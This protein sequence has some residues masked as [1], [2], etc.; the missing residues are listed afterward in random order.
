VRVLVA[1]DDP[2]M[3]KLLG[4]LVAHWGLQA[5]YASDG[6]EALAVLTGWSP[7]DR[8]LIDWM[9]PGLPGPDVCRR[10]R[11]AGCRARLVMLTALSEP[12]R[13]VEGLEAGADDYVGKPFDAAVLRARLL[14]AGATPER[15]APEVL[16]PGVVLGRFRLESVLGEG[17]MGVV[18]K[19]THV[20]LGH[21]AAVKV[22]RGD[23]AMQ[24]RPRARFEREARAM[25]ML[26]SPNVVR[27]FDYGVSPGGL[28][29]LVM[30]YLRGRTLAQL[31]AERGP[32][33][34]EDVAQ[35]ILEIARGLSA[36]H[37]AG[38]VHRDVKPENVFLED[39]DG[40]H[41]LGRPFQAKLLDFGLAR[42]A[43]AGPSAT[44]RGC[45]V[46]TLGY[47]S[48]EQVKG[49]TV[50]PAS[51][52]W[53]LGAT[54]F[55]ALTGHDAIADGRE[56]AMMRR[57][58]AGVTVLPTALAPRLP[59]AVDAWLARACAVDPNARFPD[60]VTMAEALRRAVW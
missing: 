14:R 38:L 50:S 25:S 28:P 52:L 56:S 31:L 42:S 44:G 55:A 6:D 18:F 54:A 8:A 48:P 21:P 53:S 9:M 20:E 34:P 1:D 58:K 10:A 27:I 32:L 45:F 2:E 46:G 26:R 51:D 11:A 57:T 39:T 40:D 41:D 33:P 47:A 43:L 17:G 19:A 5:V 7:P 13:V 49:G 30:E 24:P 35:L 22:V 16:R 3:R 36:A 29:Y 12:D 4:R 59:A 15:T 37:R 60:A 23:L